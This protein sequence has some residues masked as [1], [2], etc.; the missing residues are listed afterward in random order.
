MKILKFYTKQCGQCRLQSKILE[1]LE[2]IEIEPIDCTENEELV[3]KYGI[4]SLPVLIILDDNDNII[5]RFDG[6]TQLDNIKKTI[7]EYE[8]SSN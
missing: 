8:R 6:I 2:G 5:K 7:E 3:E 4:V 1:G